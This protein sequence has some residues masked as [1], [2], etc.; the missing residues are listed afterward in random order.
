MKSL[1]SIITINY[2]NLSGLIETCNSI[3]SQTFNNYEFIVIDANSNDGSVEFLESIYKK[4]NKLRIEKDNGIYDA[5]NKGKELA[6][7]DWIIF[8]N[9]GDKFHNSEVL[10]T[11]ARILP[12][13]EASII[14]GD[15]KI[16]YDN[17]NSKVKKFK[18]ITF[19]RGMPFCVQSTFINK[20][21]LTY[22]KFNERYKVYGDLDYFF[23]M[24]NRG[25]KFEY[26]EIIV[27]DFDY[28][29]ISSKFNFIYEIE[30]F[31]VLRKYNKGHALLYIPIILDKWFRHTIKK[32]LPK[33]LVRKIQLMK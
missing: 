22:D 28:N 7:S 14:F 6:S 21:F 27:S 26:M 1:I 15:V 11:V 8:M 2:N 16:K 10:E 24:Y 3:F 17:K 30:K 25:V 31:K 13:M 32:I 5:M 18:N 20:K 12:S 23:Q 19:K 33:Y 9:S 4:I 29:G